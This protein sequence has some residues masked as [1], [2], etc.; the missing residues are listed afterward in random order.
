MPKRLIAGNWKMNGLK[1]AMSEAEG[2]AKSLADTPAD[3]DVLICPPATLVS[4]M[5][6]A[7]DG[8]D[9]SVG[10]QDCHENESGAH[11]GDISAEMLADAG[12]GDS[13]ARLRRLRGRSQGKDPHQLA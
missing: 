13:I 2:V 11:T 12:A 10:G 1:A 9:I 4:Q 7:L 8:T 3:C 6:T 5:A